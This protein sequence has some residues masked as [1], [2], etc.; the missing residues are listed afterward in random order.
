M[1][2]QILAHIGMQLHYIVKMMKLFISTVLDFNIFLK[3]LENSLNVK[4]S[5][6]TF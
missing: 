2:T 1:N 6:Q 5:K 4:T 3:K